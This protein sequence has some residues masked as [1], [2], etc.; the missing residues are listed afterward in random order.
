[1]ITI[2]IVTALASCGCF[3]AIE[4]IKAAMQSETKIGATSI[5]YARQK[6][7]PQ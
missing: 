7:E 3:S 2:T 5:D 6:K 4:D 1:V